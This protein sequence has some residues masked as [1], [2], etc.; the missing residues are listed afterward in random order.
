MR[1]GEAV[2]TGQVDISAMDLLPLFQ[3]SGTGLA[4]VVV[5]RIVPREHI[6]RLVITDPAG[7][8][9]ITVAD[10][11]ILAEEVFGFEDDHD[12]VRRAATSTNG[13]S[14]YDWEGMNVAL[15]QRI[16]DRGLPATQADLIAE[17]QHWFADQSDGTKMPDSRS[18]R[19]RITPHMAGLAQ[20]RCMIDPVPG[21][22]VGSRALAIHRHGIGIMHQHGP[23]PECAGHG[24][25]PQ[26]RVHQVGVALRRLHLRM[27][28]QLA[29]HFQ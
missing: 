3:R 29:D 1:C 23:W 21:W 9:T 26:A 22:A 17:I 25:D 13:A 18:I 16:H 8:V 15:S 24:I 7:R 11:P 5:R 2:F 6:D 19:R 20:V 14:P 12:M 10:M 28:Q 4:K 27:A